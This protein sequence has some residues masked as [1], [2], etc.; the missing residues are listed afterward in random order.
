MKVVLVDNQTLFRKGLISILSQKSAID[1][2]GGAKNKHE[3]IS[4]IGREIPDVVIV[5]YYLGKESG[6]EVIRK[7]KQLGYTCNFLLLIHSKDRLSFE[8]VQMIDA[9]GYI[10]LEAH[11][12]ELMYA[13]EVIHSGRKYYDPNVIEMLIHS[14]NESP[15]DSSRVESLTME[16]Q[17]RFKKLEGA[18]STKLNHENLYI[19]ENVGKKH[20]DQVAAKLNPNN[21]TQPSAYAYEAGFA[22]YRYNILA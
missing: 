7:A 3:A 6:L 5:D 22:K 9:E 15:L 1:V 14:Q 11:P 21:R 18:L 19:T 16:E 20:A 8:D 2:L 17:G 4:L 13:L 10:S 12:G